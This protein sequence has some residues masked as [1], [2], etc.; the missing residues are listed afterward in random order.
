MTR[1]WG[2][3]LFLP[4][5]LARCSNAEAVLLVYDDIAQL[6]ERHLVLYERVSADEYVDLASG[7]ALQRLAPL[8]GFD[9]PVSYGYAKIHPFRSCGF[10]EA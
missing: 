1:I 7:R 4:Q 5:S 10:I 2:G 6:P 8:L 9:D 3:R